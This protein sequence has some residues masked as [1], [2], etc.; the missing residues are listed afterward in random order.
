MSSENMTVQEKVDGLNEVLKSMKY[1]MFTTR[2]PAGE[3]HAR[4]MTLGSTDE[5]FKFSFIANNVTFRIDEIEFDGHVNLSFFDPS[6]TCWVSVAGTAQISNDKETIDSL[7]KP[8][9]EAWFGDL[10]DGVHTGQV[11]DPRVCAIQVVP[12]SIRYWISRHAMPGG[13]AAHGEL[14][15]I[16][17][18]E[19]RVIEG[20]S[21]SCKCNH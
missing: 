9:D 16:P 18:V 8:A 1:C 14:V 3:L 13:T 20:M 19:M 10:G 2:S 5:H 4:C 21:T 11:S 6:S 17:G 12:D 7:W 15:T